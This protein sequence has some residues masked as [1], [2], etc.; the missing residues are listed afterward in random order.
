M[1]ISNKEIAAAF[2]LTAALMELH[3]ENTFRTRAYTNAYNALRKF[4]QPLSELSPD[5]LGAIPGLGKSSVEKVLEMLSTGRM[6]KLEKYRSKTPDGIIELLSIRGLGPGKVRTIWKDLQIESPG[7]LLYAC[8]ENRL[9]EARRETRSG[10]TGGHSAEA[11]VLYGVQRQM[12]V[13]QD[14]PDRK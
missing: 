2:K 9:I 11:S 7:E 5:D 10:D 13:C 12:A 6:E 3:G 1:S 14:Y 8:N 4:E